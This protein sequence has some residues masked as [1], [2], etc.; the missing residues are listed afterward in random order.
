[1]NRAALKYALA[2]TLLLSLTGSYIETARAVPK[3]EAPFVLDEKPKSIYTGDLGRDVPLLCATRFNKNLA[4]IKNDEKPVSTEVEEYV[5]TFKKSIEDYKGL[6]AAC[7]MFDLG[8]SYYVTLT[9]PPPRAHTRWDRD[10][11]G[12]KT[13]F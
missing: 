9:A 5:V 10:P 3:V 12:N 13:S 8:I 11:L 2:T 7:D 1:M 6:W 4:M